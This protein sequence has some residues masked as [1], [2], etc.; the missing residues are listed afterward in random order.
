MLL[1]GNGISADKR[2]ILLRNFFF[3]LDQARYSVSLDHFWSVRNLLYEG[4]EGEFPV[5]S[6]GFLFFISFFIFYILPLST[7]KERKLLFSVLLITT[8]DH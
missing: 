2:G 6:L 3:F 4:H 5:N 1:A 7:Q 8:C